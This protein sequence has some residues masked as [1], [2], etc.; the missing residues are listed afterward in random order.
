MGWTLDLLLEKVHHE[1][2]SVGNILEYKK[3]SLCEE[4]LLDIT[5]ETLVPKVQEAA[6]IL[7][8]FLR[9]AAYTPVQE[10]RNKTKKDPDPV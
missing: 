8:K 3:E 6:P 10:A 2:K 4:T 5:F 1:M 9:H 7:W